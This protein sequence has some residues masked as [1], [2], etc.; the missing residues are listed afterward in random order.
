M[1]RKL[2]TAPTLEPLTLT[3]TKDHLHID[4]A[5]HDALISELI[6]AAR[7]HAEIYCER[8]LL[9]QTWDVFLDGFPLPLTRGVIEIPLGELQSITD[10]NYIDGAGVNQLLAT[11]VYQVDAVSEPARVAPKSGQVW[12]ATLL[13]MNVVTIRFVAGYGN[14]PGDVPAG[15]REAMLM[16]IAHFY[17]HRESVIVGTIVSEMKQST[18]WALDSYRILKDVY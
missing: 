11:S 10:I 12:P 3:E 4:V 15:I 14:S 5:T 7:R 2:I 18:N 17:E 8:A 9:T 16:L 1:P 6:P 13:E